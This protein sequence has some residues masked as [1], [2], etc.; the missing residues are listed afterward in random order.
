[1]T[2]IL[3]WLWQGFTIA[4]HHIAASELKCIK[5]TLFRGR[6]LIF[7]DTHFRA[8]KTLRLRDRIDATQLENQAAVLSPGEFD[9]DVFCD[10]SSDDRHA[11]FRGEHAIIV[12]NRLDA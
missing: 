10:R 8:D 2:I 6:K 4:C 12:E 7:R 9:P 1:M 3:T 5:E 11:T